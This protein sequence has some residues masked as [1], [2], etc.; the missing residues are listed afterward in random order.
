MD[1][2][3]TLSAGDASTHSPGP[4]HSGRALFTPKSHARR[5]ST[6]N[7]HTNGKHNLSSNSSSPTGNRGNQILHEIYKYEAVVDGGGGFDLI[8]EACL[9]VVH[10]VSLKNRIRFV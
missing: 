2:R 3:E 4:A 9:N 7:H 8:S 5:S 1:L 10:C 6:P